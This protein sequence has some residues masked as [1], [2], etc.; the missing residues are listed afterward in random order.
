ML[1]ASGRLPIRS[2]HWFTLEEIKIV[3]PA[4][5]RH[6]SASNPAKMNSGA[7]EASGAN[8]CTSTNSS[9]P[10]LLPVFTRLSA[11]GS[12][13]A[14]ITPA[15]Y[16]KM[17]ITASRRPRRPNPAIAAAGPTKIRSSPGGDRQPGRYLRLGHLR[18]PGE[19]GRCGEDPQAEDQRF[20]RIRY[21]RVRDAGDLEKAQD[22]GRGSRGC[23]RADDPP[24]PQAAG[25]LAR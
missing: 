18:R 22:R 14:K 10:A 25:P 20:D 6:R 19:Q 21:I 15:E 2:V 9:I 16:A 8:H 7:S 24:L 11:N 17:P 13:D 12:A 3:M 4:S 23:C 1:N 5:C